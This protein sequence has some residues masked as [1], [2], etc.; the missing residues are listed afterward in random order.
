MQAFLQIHVSQLKTLLSAGARSSQEIEANLGVSSIVISEML[1]CLGS[2][3]VRFSVQGE[4][5]YAWFDRRRVSLRS[6][7]FRADTQG[8]LER[9]GTLEPVLPEGYVLVTQDGADCYSEGTPWWLYDV[10]PQGYLGRLYARQH[11]KRLELPERLC[12]WLDIYAL[13]TVQQCGIGLPGS[14]LIG[15]DLEHRLIGLQKVQQI[16]LAG[17]ADSYANMASE[18]EAGSFLCPWVPGEQPKFIA[19]AETEH[20]SA[21]VIV[22]FSA[23]SADSVSERWRDLLLAEHI[24]LQVLAQS[25]VLAAKSCVIDHGGRRFL[26]LERFDRV[27][28]SGR[29]GLCSLAALDDEFVGTNGPWYEVTRALES[30]GFVEQASTERAAFLWAFGVLIGNNDMHNGNMSFV[31]SHRGRPYQMA[32]AYDMTPMAFAPDSVGEIRN[33][34]RSFRMAD[35][36]PM[37]VWRAALLVAEHY[38]WRMQTDAR[39]SVS[40]TPC[41]NAIRANLLKAAMRI[42]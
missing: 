23:A 9:L 33:D 32:P 1:G 18:C 35:A 21:H 28:E 36:V 34:L 22:K 20:G 42:A 41:I 31:V 30:Q 13:E 10:L 8:Q 40:F 14:L 38:A 26:E 7:V 29:V 3:V 27:G 16:T 5:H 4:I 17:K 24:A 37:A 11:A 39:F 6:S 2:E 25:G 19:Y 15:E 12:D